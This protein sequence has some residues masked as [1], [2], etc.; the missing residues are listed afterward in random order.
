MKIPDYGRE[1]KLCLEKSNGFLPR[2][3]EG[4]RDPDTLIKMYCDLRRDYVDVLKEN[5]TLKQRNDKLEKKNKK[6]SD[7]LWV[8]N[9]CGYMGGA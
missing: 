9:G 1:N 6:M 2:E 8:K 4:I 5:S 7:E 3:I